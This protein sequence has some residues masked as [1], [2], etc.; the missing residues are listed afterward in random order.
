MN[1]MMKIIAELTGAILGMLFSL[2]VAL[3]L[4]W[5]IVFLVQLIIGVVFFG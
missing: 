5:V 4:V 3:S 2:A 1:K